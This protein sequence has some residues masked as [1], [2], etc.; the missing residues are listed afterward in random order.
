MK[1]NGNQRYGSLLGAVREEAAH[2]RD[3]IK[4]SG[5]NALEHGREQ[6]A[7]SVGVCRE[8]LDEAAGQLHSSHLEGT[9]AGLERAAESVGRIEDYFRSADAETL[10]QD[11]EN[12]IRRNQT[13]AFSTFFL[14]GL[15]L[16]RFLKA[17][18][19][20]SGTH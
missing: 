16:G 5:Q 7:D 14:S 6:L 18:R 9:A 3:N 1:R 19:P 15:A 13:A 20:V 10:I 8:M 2:V 12:C 17:G 11:T 4:D